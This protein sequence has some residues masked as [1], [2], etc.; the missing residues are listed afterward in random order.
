MATD[1]KIH[2]TFRS[3]SSEPRVG[4][5]VMNTN[6]GCKHHRSEGNVVGIEEL[7]E[8]MGKIISYR[9]TNAGPTYRSGDVL[10][11]TMDQVSPIHYEDDY[12]EFES[13]GWPMAGTSDDIDRG[14]P[15]FIPTRD[16]GTV[17]VYKGDPEYD[18]HF[19]RDMMREWFQNRYD[20]ILKD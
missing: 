4:D 5:R 16:R 7:P 3:H 13:A 20:N 11:K 1:R 18:E 12:D 8:D 6:P 15:R 9:V 17:K 2:E 10:R 19:S 14:P